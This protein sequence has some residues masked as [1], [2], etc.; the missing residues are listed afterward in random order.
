MMTRGLAGTR[1]TKMARA[2]YIRRA[3]SGCVE[4]F[5]HNR[6]IRTPEDNTFTMTMGT[7]IIT[8]EMISLPTNIIHQL[9]AGWR[10]EVRPQRNIY[11]CHCSH[12]NHLCP[13]CQYIFSPCIIIIAGSSHALREPRQRTDVQ[14]RYDLI[15][16]SYKIVIFYGQPT[17]S[18]NRD[19]GRQKL[20]LTF[21][22]S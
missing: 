9:H 20:K 14:W 8:T 16:Q 12:T 11:Q 2:D 4:L 21:L 7:Q 10:I 13:V 22:S 3:R 18:P 19:F 15:L 5:A 17:H 6:A 1:R